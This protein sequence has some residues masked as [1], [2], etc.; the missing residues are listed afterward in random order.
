MN[1]NKPA[2]S[3]IVPVYNRPEVVISALQ[4]V[5][6]QT[7]TDFEVV[8]VDDGS[9]PPLTLPE[10]IGADDRV[11]IIHLA[12]NQGPSAARNAGAR[13]A[14]G[15]WLAWLDSD[16]AWHDDKLSKQMH[17]LEQL[18]RPDA[19]IALATGFEYHHSTGKREQRIPLPASTPLPFFSGCWY[20]P[21]TTLILS[22]TSF[23]KVGGFDEDML[24]LEDIDWFAR[25]ALLGG[26]LEIVPEVLVA[27][28][29]GAKAPYAKVQKAG[30]YLL[31]KFNG[32]DWDLPSGA[33]NQLSAYLNIEYAASAISCDHNYLRGLG[34]LAA[35]WFRHPRA[36]LHLQKFWR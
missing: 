1:V 29:T 19:M 36:R 25:F 23:A 7:F 11:K 16:D 3:V 15:Q 30:A 32:E 18:N 6:D 33:R 12:R 5:L 17:Y 35:S 34:H 2:V 20:C 27:I 22:A 24:R 8:V 26:H 10:K 21:G 9:T 4:S 14:R 13:A 31:S 28:N